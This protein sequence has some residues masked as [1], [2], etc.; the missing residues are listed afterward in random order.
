MINFNIDIKI[1]IKTMTDLHENFI[2]ECYIYKKIKGDLYFN[3]TIFK[4]IIFLTNEKI[5]KEMEPPEVSDGVF[6]CF[7][8]KSKKTT[9]IPVQARSADEPMTNFVTCLNC[10]NKWKS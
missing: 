6:F 2:K 8:C 4:D 7:K 9:S 10:G 1:N 3:E 5:R